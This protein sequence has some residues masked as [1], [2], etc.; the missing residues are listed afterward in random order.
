MKKPRFMI[1]PGVVNSAH[2]NGSHMIT[3]RE[4][5]RLYGVQK[6]DYINTMDPRGRGIESFRYVHL[7]PD[8]TGHYDLQEVVGRD[9]LN[10][11]IDI[12][13]K[14]EISADIQYI[15]NSNKY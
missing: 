12:F 5:V 6:D 9:L 8:P 11:L 7:Y 10:R 3:V 1:H 14:F 2:D 15:M 4:L 13:V